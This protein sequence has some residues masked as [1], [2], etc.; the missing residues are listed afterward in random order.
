M[1]TKIQPIPTQKKPRKPIGSIN[2]ERADC[3]KA[4]ARYPKAN[5]FWCCHHAELFEMPN[6][7]FK[8]MQ[9]VKFRLAFIHTDKEGR[10]RAIRY[11]NF[12][13]VKPPGK[14]KLTAKL[15]NEQWPNNTWN[16]SSIF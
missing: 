7:P 5:Y 3:L 6:H 14:R 12:R 11:R 8:I 13:P 1:S 16:G 9:S 10:E 4:F 2:A 15:F